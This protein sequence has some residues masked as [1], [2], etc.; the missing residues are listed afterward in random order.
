MDWIPIFQ[1]FSGTWAAKVIA[2][3][4][5]LF[6]AI[7]A[8]HIVALTVLLGAILFLDLQMLGVVRR[9]TPV[10][11]LADELDPWLFSSLVIILFSGLLLFSSEAM[12]LY[13]SVPFKL[14][15]I[16]LLLAIV[17]HF[18][19]QRWVIRADAVRSRPVWNRVTA[20]IS[21]LLWLTVGFS[22]RAIGFF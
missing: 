4:I 8:I 14:K 16:A 10:G 1:W 18:T 20:A 3:S 11:T 2:D 19:I 17:F 22:G 13:I 5:W 6:P 7:E 15:M 21:I 12:K 9:D